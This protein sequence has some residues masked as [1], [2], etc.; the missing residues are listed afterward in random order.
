MLLWR[1]LNWHKAGSNVQNDLLDENFHFLTFD[2]F[3]EKF[4]VKTSLLQ[5]QSVLS[6]VSKMKSLSACTQAVTNTVKDLS[7]LLAS[8]DFCKLAYKML[9]KQIASIP[10]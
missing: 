10:L 9:I 7:N 3:K 4:S 6:A 5:Y 1:N 2:A 8:T